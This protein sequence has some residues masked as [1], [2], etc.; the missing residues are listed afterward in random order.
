MARKE[1]RKGNIVTGSILLFY[2]GMV[3]IAGPK[4]DRACDG[5]KPIE[6]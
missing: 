6:P 2:G 5:F 1:S 3:Y 4:N